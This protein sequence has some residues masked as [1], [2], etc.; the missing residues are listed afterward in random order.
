MMDFI[1]DV[2]RFFITTWIFF[3]ATGFVFVL[4]TRKAMKT[5]AY[6]VLGLT[7]A[8][9]YFFGIDYVLMNNLQGLP[10]PYSP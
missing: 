1:M 3:I 4:A 10:F 6:Y 2:P 7:L 9:A 5:F 8:F